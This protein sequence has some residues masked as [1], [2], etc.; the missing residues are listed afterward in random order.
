MSVEILQIIFLL[1]CGIFYLRETLLL[2]GGMI[3]HGPLKM[4]KASAELEIDAQWISNE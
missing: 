2:C 3:V 1:C 4:S